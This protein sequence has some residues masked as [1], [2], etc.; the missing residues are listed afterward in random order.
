MNRGK[1]I[2]CP[3]SRLTR[4]RAEIVQALLVD[5]GQ[6]VIPCQADEV[7]SPEA[8]YAFVRLGPIADDISETPDPVELS[9]IFYHGIQRGKVRMNVRHEENTHVHFREY[10]TTESSIL[11]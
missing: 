6:I 4:V 5:H 7:K 11:Q 1:A 9:G 8:L 10:C 3:K 2:A